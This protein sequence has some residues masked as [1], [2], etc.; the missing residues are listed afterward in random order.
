MLQQQN[1]EL[2]VLEFGSRKFTAPERNWDTREREAYGI[3]W[4]CEHYSDYLRCHH[5]IVLTDH[6]SLTWIDRS[7]AGKVQRWALYLQQFDIEIRHLPGI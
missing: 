4:A 7:L 6:E 1:R 3:K 5:V 2:V